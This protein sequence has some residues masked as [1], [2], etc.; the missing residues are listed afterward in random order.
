MKKLTT[1]NNTVYNNGQI[2]DD[3]HWWKKND[4]EFWKNIFLDTA[5]PTVLELAS[6]TG[7]LAIPLIREGAEYTG[8][9]L[10]KDFCKTSEQKLKSYPKTTISNSDMRDFNLKKKFDLIFIGFNSFL[11]L[12]TDDDAQMCLHCVRKHI[13]QKGRFVIDIFA[14]NPLFL[15]RPHGMRFALMEYIDSKT[16]ETISIEESNEYNPETEINEISWYYSSQSQQDFDLMKFTLRM[17]YP[18]TMNRI[19]TDAGFTIL[20][21]WGDYYRT[22]FNE[23]SKLQIY[24]CSI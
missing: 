4:I 10:S 18:D 6:G 11:H 1:Y 21:V 20:D 8:V 2:Y 16:N 24:N 19:L 9:E 3:E 12:L 5:G 13:K 17:F 14:P 22:P 23:G 7:R 15:Y